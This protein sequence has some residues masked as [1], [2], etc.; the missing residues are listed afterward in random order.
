M[1]EAT[2]AIAPRRSMALFAVLSI[3]M[4]LASYVFANKGAK[5]GPALGK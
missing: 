4:V 1:S 5:Q 2:V 3:L